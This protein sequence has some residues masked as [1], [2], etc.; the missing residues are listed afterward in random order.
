MASAYVADKRV[1]S[2]PRTVTNVTFVT[3]MLSSF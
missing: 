3:Y 2:P 1:V